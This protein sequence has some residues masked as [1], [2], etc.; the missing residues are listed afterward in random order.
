MLSRLEEKEAHIVAL[1]SEDLTSTDLATVKN[2]VHKH[3]EFL[4]SLYVIEKQVQELCREADRMMQLFPRTQ[5]HLEVRRSE[6]EEQLKDVQDGARKFSERL[7]QAQNN[8]AY[9]QEIRALNAWLRHMESK[10]TGEVLPRSVSACDTLN[11][12]HAEYRSEIQAHEPQKNSLV[13]QGRKMISSGNALSSEISLKI[14]DLEAGFRDIFDIWRHRQEVYDEN[15]DVQKWLNTASKLE[16]WLAE[17]EGLLNED[18]H[19]VENAETVE[20]M[21]RQFDDFLATL[22]AQGQNFESLK[23]LTK[24]EQNWTNMRAREEE[25][26]ISRRSSG[27]GENRRET[28]TIKT[29]EKKKILQEKRQERERRK[30]QEISLLKRSPSQV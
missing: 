28:Q 2:L 3:D 11:V 4:H 22:E 1:D 19:S 7:A 25:M 27:I 18:W 15:Y 17:R 20:E 29:V 5:A 12:R 14:E 8:Q 30:T 6:L 9:F 16:K 24:L 26:T 21:I 13:N 10:I 23:R